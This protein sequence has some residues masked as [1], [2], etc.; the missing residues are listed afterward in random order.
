MGSQKALQD[1]E[2]R[3]FAARLK[4]AREDS[5]QS[6]EKLAASMG[7]SQ[8]FVSRCELGERRVDVI[9]FRDFCKALGLPPSHFVKGFPKAR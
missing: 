5:G 8:R 9:E 7:R 4:K 3:D 6:Q 1:D 2:Y